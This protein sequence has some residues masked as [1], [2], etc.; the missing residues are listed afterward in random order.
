MKKYTFTL[1]YFKYVDEEKEYDQIHHRLLNERF[2][3]I[4]ISV[5]T[6]AT[7]D[8]HN[9]ARKIF[10]DLIDVELKGDHKTKMYIFF[11]KVISIEELI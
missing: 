7:V 4:K 2:E 10:Q 3:E 8:A 9:K 6:Q 1:D 11:L 5:N